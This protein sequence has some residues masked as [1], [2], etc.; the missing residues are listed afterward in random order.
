MGITTIH[1]LTCNDCGDGWDDYYD[2]DERVIIRQAIED[3]WVL[4]PAKDAPVGE[5][6]YL[7]PNCKGE[8]SA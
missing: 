7:C 5:V 2:A 4:Q 1:Y 8:V 3:G 6:G